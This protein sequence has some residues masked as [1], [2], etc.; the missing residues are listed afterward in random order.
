MVDQDFI[1][2]LKELK[3]K[4]PLEYLKVLNAYKLSNSELYNEIIKAITSGK[5]PAEKEG[6]ARTEPEHKGY[7]FNLE[8]SEPI[9]EEKKEDKKKD[10]K[11]NIEIITFLAVFGLVAVLIGIIILFFILPK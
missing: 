5:K 2:N 6:P 9:I 4:N 3:E 10:K 1:N 8:Q 7:P 11:I